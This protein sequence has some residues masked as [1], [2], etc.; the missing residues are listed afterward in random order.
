MVFCSTFW[1]LFF[2][3]RWLYQS[4][5][6]A[7]RILKCFFF[8]LF[9]DLLRAMPVFFHHMRC[10]LGVQYVSERDG[11]DKRAHEHIPIS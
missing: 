6:L 5:A 8:G 1:C 3:V 10:L 7:Q 9:R 4:Q 2:F 11:P